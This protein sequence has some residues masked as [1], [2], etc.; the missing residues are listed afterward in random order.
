MG[1]SALLMTV[2]LASPF[3]IGFVEELKAL[4]DA[5]SDAVSIAARIQVGLENDELKSEKD[6][7]AACQYAPVITGRLPEARVRN[8]V[9]PCSAQPGTIY[10]TQ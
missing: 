5:K 9:C 7:L 4:A 10:L 1:I 2:A 8:Q 3:H 6:F